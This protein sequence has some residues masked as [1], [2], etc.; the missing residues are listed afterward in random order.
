MQQSLIYHFHELADRYETPE[1]IIGDPS[2][3]MHQV[4]GQQNQEAM[5]FIASCL[6]YGS[7]KQFLPKIDFMLHASDGKVYDWIVSGDFEKDIP[8][9]KTRCYYRL[10]KFSDIH[11]LLRGLQEILRKYGSLAEYC[12]S[13]VGP[14]GNAV[15]F[16]SDISSYFRALGLKGIV[17]AP[18]SSVC[19]RP[20]MFLR[21]MVRDNSPV[22]LGL[23]KDIVDSS[24]LI[25]PLDTH[26][27]QTAR[28][29]GLIETQSTSWHTAVSLTNL[30][31]EA[32]PGDPARG[33]FALYGLGID[34]DAAE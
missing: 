18:L 12:R 28:H 21:W 4:V 27:V 6:S 2:W 17:P 30:M 14:E 20:C 1:F 13:V 10:Y 7:R 15:S 23:W 16:L 31:A 29:F 34:Q 9:D 33:D 25:I 22:D 26:V 8:L 11:M 32:F 24:T 3:F 5:A 19:K